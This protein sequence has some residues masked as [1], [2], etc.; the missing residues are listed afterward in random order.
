M[1]MIVY[2]RDE[3]GNINKDSTL[4][5][6]SQDKINSA[7]KELVEG[8]ETA[9]NLKANTEAIKNLSDSDVNAMLAIAEIYET[10][11]NMKV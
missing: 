1:S 8:T 5:V 4:F 7:V 9:K 6:E 2:Q 11:L 10:I 3:H